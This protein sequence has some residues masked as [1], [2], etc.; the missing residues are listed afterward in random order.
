[1]DTVHAIL[2]AFYVLVF[3]LDLYTTRSIL[4]HE[5]KLNA[6]RVLNRKTWEL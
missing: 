5:T 4:G 1:M 2:L 6:L 3:L